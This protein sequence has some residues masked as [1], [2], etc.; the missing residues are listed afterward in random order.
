MSVPAP[1]AT[2]AGVGLDEKLLPNSRGSRG[3]RRVCVSLDGGSAFLKGRSAVPGAGVQVAI[4]PLLCARDAT[5]PLSWGWPGVG[6]DRGQGRGKEGPQASHACLCISPMALLTVASGPLRPQWLSS[7]GLSWHHFSP[8]R[9]HRCG[10]GGQFPQCL[11]DGSSSQAVCAHLPCPVPTVSMAGVAC[12]R[13]ATAAWVV[14]KDPAARS[15]IGCGGQKA[16]APPRLA[17]LGSRD[18]GVLR[19]GPP[20]S[21]TE[22]R[23]GDASCPGPFEGRALNI[24][25]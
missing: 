23:G 15:G 21:T 22:S 13:G 3:S 5:E 19:Q 1:L 2:R 14:E 24:F 8:C 10:G 12:A 6:G 11:G 7:P 18:S 4:L 16:R 20:C 9:E 25:L 17:A